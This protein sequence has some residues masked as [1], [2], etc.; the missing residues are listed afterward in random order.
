MVC[1]AVTTTL[2]SLLLAACGGPGRELAQT[3]TPEVPKAF[4]SR[5]DA[6]RPELRPLVVEWPATDRAALEA[7][8]LH[9][10]VVVR[11]EGCALELLPQCKVKKAAAYS[12]TPI[13][14]KDEVVT[15]ANE[16]E[17][18]ANIPAFAAKF[19]AKLRSS[20]TLSAAMRIVGM[21][22][23]RGLAPTADELEG[24]CAHATHV[25]TGIPTGSFEF[26]AGGHTRAGAS[27]TVA[28]TGGGAD[29][30]TSSE[31][32]SRDGDP[33]ACAT[34]KR[35]D[36]H[37]PERCGALLRLELASLRQKAPVNAECPPGTAQVNGT[38]VAAAAMPATVA[39][40]TAPTTAAAVKVT[41]RPE[42]LAPEDV[43]GADQRKA[44][45]WGNRCFLHIQAGA[46][47]HA[48]AACERG[49]AAESSASIRGAILYNMG[50]V[51]EKDGNLQAACSAF[52][53]SIE[54]R[55]NS[56]VS[57]KYRELNCADRAP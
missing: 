31:T 24:E 21:Y 46:V 48:R 43:A 25:V 32:L 26:S 27:T 6:K 4:S 49:L 50:L 19:E 56:V 52:R 17:L 2:C 54:A 34:S 45:D 1:R 38:C 55:P 29:K 47:R 33:G 41:F 40:V 11:Y 37:P 44:A 5:C 3:Q 39:T 22:E 12:Y 42:D 20:G 15:M 28:G 7:A 35:D 10:Q 8:A 23:A 36:A 16:Q 9:G 51:E 30:Q 53:R 57:G 18:Y 13:T 14:P